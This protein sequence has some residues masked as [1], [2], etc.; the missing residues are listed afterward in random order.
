M[1]I[2]IHKSEVSDQIIAF[3]D[4]WIDYGMTFIVRGKGFSSWA[5]QE[6]NKNKMFNQK[7][8]CIGSSK[9]F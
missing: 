5:Q 3:H 8:H 6:C 7:F 1:I 4:R 9:K 2:N